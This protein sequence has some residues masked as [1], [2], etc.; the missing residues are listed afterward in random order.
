MLFDVI[1]A[2]T[3]KREVDSDN[4][5][6]KPYMKAIQEVIPKPLFFDGDKYILKETLLQ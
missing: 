5:D 4:E 3:E 2:L 1:N 6:L